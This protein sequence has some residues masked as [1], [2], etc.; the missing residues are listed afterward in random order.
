MQTVLA[1]LKNHQPGTLC[2]TYAKE[3][4]NVPVGADGLHRFGLPQELSS[5]AFRSST[6]ENLDSALLL[7]ARGGLEHGK[8]HL[9]ELSYKLDL[10]DPRSLNIIEIPPAPIAFTA[11]RLFLGI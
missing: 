1:E 11:L 4:N 8:I 10:S 3:A 2:N 9:A 5:V 7:L 6:A